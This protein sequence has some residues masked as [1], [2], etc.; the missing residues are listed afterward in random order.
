MKLL[1]AL[2]LGTETNAVVRT[3]ASLAG[4]SS[5]S[6]ALLHVLP[7]EKQEIEF[8]PTIT[9]RYQPPPKYYRESEST[10]EGSTVPLLHDKRFKEMQDIA[11]SLNSEGIDATFSFVHGNPVERIVETAKKEEAD[12]ILLGSHGHTPLYQCLIGSVC[13]GV[14][15]ASH[16]PVIVI[17]KSTGK[18]S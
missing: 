3:A 1:A 16:V 12:Y 6:I 10:G 9:P 15:N 13:S 4:S 5:A 2:D 8:H 18:K 11:E 17:P 14:V 7:E